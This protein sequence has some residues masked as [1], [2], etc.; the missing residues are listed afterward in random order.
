MTGFI[1]IVTM[2]ALGVIY[3]TFLARLVRNRLR[4]NS[5]I[6]TPNGRV[7]LLA[8]ATIVI[9]MLAIVYFSILDWWFVVIQAVVFI[10]LLFRGRL[11]IELKYNN[12][13]LW[14]IY[15]RYC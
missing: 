5:W 14:V 13:F 1:I 2:I 6:A 15:Y 7:I 4:W 8:V 9:A 11:S 10:I 12:V 3:H